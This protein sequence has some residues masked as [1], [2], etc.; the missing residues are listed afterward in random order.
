[1]PV[2]STAAELACI[3]QLTALYGA[4]PIEEHLVHRRHRRTP[5][6]VVAVAFTYY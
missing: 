4:L 2:R 5:S 6:V 1:M 3:T